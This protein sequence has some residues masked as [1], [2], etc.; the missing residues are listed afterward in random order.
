[1]RTK[2]AS[3]IWD[4]DTVD[5]LWRKHRVEFWEVEEVVLDDEHAKFRWHRSK[6]HGRRLLVCGR[7]AGGRRLLVV[8]EPADAKSGTWQCRT[9]WGEK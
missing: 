4:D 5:K 8:L 2:L 3:L 6:R 7:T 9:A 1:M